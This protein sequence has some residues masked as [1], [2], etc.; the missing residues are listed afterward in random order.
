MLIMEAVLVKSQYELDRD[1]P[2]PSK[3]HSII[4]TDLIIAFAKKYDNLRILS[5][6]S[7]II[8][9]KEKIPDLAIYNKS[10]FETKEE[11][12]TKQIPLGV[13]EILSPFQN[14]TE[15]IEKSKLY[16][17]AGVKTYWLI[18][19]ALKAA[20]VYHQ[21]EK[22]TAFMEDEILKDETLDVEIELAKVFP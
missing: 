2:M 6:L 7:M 17:L 12:K 11:V 1:K 18:V 8:N 14:I 13:V 5:E 20:F 3:H 9:G 16:F 22:Y 19:P 4:Q 10:E 21:P 15:L